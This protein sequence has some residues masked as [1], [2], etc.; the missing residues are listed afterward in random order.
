MS[1]YNHTPH[2]SDN[3]CQDLGSKLGKSNKQDFSTTNY[4]ENILV[5]SVYTMLFLAIVAGFGGKVVGN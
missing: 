3:P 1:K 5:L 2:N 4:L